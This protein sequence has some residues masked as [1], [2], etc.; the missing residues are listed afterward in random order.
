MKCPDT[1]N[2]LD[3]QKFWCFY[4]KREFY[5]SKDNIMSKEYYLCG[6][7]NKKSIKN[8]FEKQ[9]EKDKYK[10]I[11]ISYNEFMDN[12]KQ[13]KNYLKK[14]LIADSLWD[15]NQFYTIIGSVTEY[16][17]IKDKMM[18]LHELKQK[19]KSSIDLLSSVY[20]ELKSILS[21]TKSLTKK[22]LLTVGLVFKRLESTSY[23]DNDSSVALLNVDYFNFHFNTYKLFMEYFY[24]RF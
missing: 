10:K 24:K 7:T 17:I 9:R 16:D 19:L 4:L 11:K 14:T 8:L 21:I 15:G 1:E 18:D 6:I 3:E 20:E 12:L 5:S 2:L 22:N 23:S 13:D